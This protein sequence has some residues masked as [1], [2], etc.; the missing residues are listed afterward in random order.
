MARRPGDPDPV[1]A[2]AV[3]GLVALVGLW[4]LMA[5]LV[6]DYP[7]GYPDLRAVVVDI[8]MGSLV[9]VLG[10][11]AAAAPSLGQRA[12]RL[13]LVL[14]LLLMILPIVLGYSGYEELIQAERNDLF[15]GAGI[16]LLSL[17]AVFLGRRQQH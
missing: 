12:R 6:L 5:P 8:V 10:G 2:R 4:V 17:G 15:S 7:T 9:L 16:V 1:P 13:T 14:G 11:F 3:S